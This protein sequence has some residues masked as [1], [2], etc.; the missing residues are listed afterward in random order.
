MYYGIMVGIIASK[1]VRSDFNPYIFM[2]PCTGYTISSLIY[3]VV[4]NKCQCGSL[5][6]SRVT[7]W[8][9]FLTSRRS[10]DRILWTVPWEKLVSSSIS[11]SVILRSD[12]IRASTE[13]K[14][15]Y[16]GCWLSV[17]AAIEQCKLGVHGTC[18]LN[19]PWH[20]LQKMS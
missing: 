10:S 2:I 7:Q 4:R 11:T 15:S 8:A 16:T 3:G 6:R 1:K 9:V 14:A 17:D 20:H 5:V 13:T 19:N 12:K 18:V